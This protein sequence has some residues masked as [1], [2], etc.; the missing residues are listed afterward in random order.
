MRAL[1]I[2]DLHSNEPALTAVLRRVQRKRLDRIFCLG[3]VVGYGA[4]PN[5][6]LDMLRGLRHRRTFIRGNHDRVVLGSDDGGTFNEV[7]RQA[8]LWT[9]SHLS[10]ANASFL[11]SFI[12]GPIVVDGVTLCHGSP[13]DEDEYL[14]N[15]RDAGQALSR[16]AATWITLFGHTHLPTVFELDEQGGLSGTI[17]RSGATVRLNRSS[18]YLINPGSVGQPRDRNPEASA[19][20]LDTGKGTLQILRVPYPRERAQR[21]IEAAGLPKILA[22]RL[23]YGS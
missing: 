14:V 20:I 8:A 11:R 22:T 12:V 10:R 9:R 1:V 15:I 7:A 3:D 21:A 13:F 16:T 4:Q 17:I 6:V 23:D 18:R 5:Q 19:A 2:S